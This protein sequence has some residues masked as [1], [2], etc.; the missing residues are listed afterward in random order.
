MKFWNALYIKTITTMAFSCKKL[1]QSVASL[2]TVMGTCPLYL[3]VRLWI[4]QMY[5]L[6]F[7]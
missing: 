3:I 7:T 4:R 5:L 2:A 1:T 6:L